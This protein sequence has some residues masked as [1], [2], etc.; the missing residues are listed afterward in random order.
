M[1]SSA[2][3]PYER[4]DELRRSLRMSTAEG[5]FATPLV[6]INLPAN[7]VVAALLSEG[8]TL[9]PDMYGLLVSLPFWCNLLQL[10]IAPILLTRFTARSVFLGHVWLNLAV[11]AV[12]AG[13]LVYAPDWTKAHGGVVASVFLFGA[14]LTTAVAAVA[15]TTYTQSWVPSRIRAVYFSQRNR[16]CQLSNLAFLLLAG[17]VLGGSELWIFGLVI[18]LSTVMR[19]ISAVIAERTPAAGD[20][21]PTGGAS[22]AEQWNVLKRQ[23]VFW[24]MVYFGTAWGMVANGFGAFQP[25]FMLDSLV[26]SPREASIPL[27]MSLLF[28]ALAMPA[29]G[30]LIARFGA[31][32]VLFCAVP[33]WIIANLPWTFVTRE[34]DW[35]LLVTWPLTG[36]INAGIVLAQLN[37]L[38]KLLPAGAKALAVGCNTA[39]TALGTAI[40]PMV[41]G[42][43]LSWWIE[44]RWWEPELV[45]QVFFAFLPLCATLTLLLLRRVQEPQA[46]PVEHVVG[47]LRNFRM[48]A[49]TLGLGFLA[50]AL[51][52]PRGEKKRA[53]Y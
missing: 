6:Y 19:I 8:L 28:G 5:I 49:G 40:A 22:Y 1:S 11:W 21:V 23:K 45:Y 16:L 27:A 10:F 52:T 14:G 42:A 33:L 38:M 34:Q 7:L 51:F 39:A 9:A 48:L 53:E 47:A 44:R 4:R 50:Q 35:L 17:L 46:A 3:T 13:A 18:G 32:P 15:W 41:A 12:F 29:W 25:V 26:E 31:R 20:P 37:L 2:L 24:Q 30:R 43:L 36:A